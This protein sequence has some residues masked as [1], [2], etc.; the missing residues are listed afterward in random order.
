MQANLEELLVDE[1][2]D[3]YYAEKQLVKTL[4]KL[5]KAA[6]SSELRQAFESHLKETEGHVTRLEKAFELLDESARG[7]TCHGILGII[8]EGDELIKTHGRKK[9]SALDAGLIAGG[10]RAEHYEMA[11]Y[12]TLRAWAEALGHDEVAD[13]LAATLEEEKAADEKLSEL[14]EAGI[15]DAATVSKANGRGRAEEKDK[16]DEDEGEN[17]KELG[18]TS[19]RKAGGAERRP[20][21]MKMTGNGRSGQASRRAGSRR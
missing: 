9:G 18:R 6:S 21:R 12:G 14:A 3:I 4:P 5:A 8:E 2:R 15:N 11:A 7:K 17:S 20:A 10:Q 19:D 16:D 1:L 13:L